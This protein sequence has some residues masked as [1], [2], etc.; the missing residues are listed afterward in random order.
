MNSAPQGLRENKEVLDNILS[1][2]ADYD[3]PDVWCDKIG[4]VNGTVP[5]QRVIKSER[6]FI[7]LNLPASS[8]RSFHSVYVIYIG[9]NFC[10]IE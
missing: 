9:M 6:I 7:S 8:G 4:E 1:D 5:T 2:T 3:K 10:K